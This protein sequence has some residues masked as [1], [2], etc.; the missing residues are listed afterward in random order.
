MAYSQYS[1][2]ISISG[3]GYHQGNTK[4]DYFNWKISKNGKLAA[5]ASITLSFS[6]RINDYVGI[7]ALQSFIFKDCIGHFSGITHFGVNFHDDIIGWRN[8]KNQ[9]SATLGPF[10]YY[11]KNWIKK[12]EYIPTKGFLKLSENSIWE[13]KFVWYGGQV[14]YSYFHNPHNALTINFL[15]AIPYLYTFSIG[16]KYKN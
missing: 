16:S 10:W 4:T 5:F 9:F 6:Y 7:K 11:R 13:H 3:I 14:E 12:Q 15:P 2:G 1:I 8:Q